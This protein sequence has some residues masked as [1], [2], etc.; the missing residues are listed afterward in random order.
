[1]LC[2][3]LRVLPVFTRCNTFRVTCYATEK[4]GDESR[5]MCYGVTPKEFARVAAIFLKAPLRG[6]EGSERCHFSKAPLRGGEHTLLSLGNAVLC[7]TVKHR[8]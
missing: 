4:A 6:G 3:V 1:M 5:V 7:V 8:P 2:Y